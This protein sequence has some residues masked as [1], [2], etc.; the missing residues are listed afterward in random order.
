MAAVSSSTVSV[1]QA[2]ELRAVQALGR[3]DSEVAFKLIDRYCRIGAPRD[4][5]AYVIRSEALIRLGHKGAALSDLMRAL[6]LD[7]EHLIGNRRLLRWG[8]RRQ[9]ERAARTLIKIERDFA[10]LRK[11][12][13][14]LRA[15]GERGAFGAVAALEASIEG[16]AVWRGDAPLEVTVR[17]EES[18]ATV[19]F[20]ADRDHALA[21]LGR[22]VS[23]SVK[24]PESTRSQRIAV[25]ADGQKIC[26][27]V[28]PPRTSPQWAAKEAPDGAETRLASIAVIV[29]IFEDAAA[30][31]ACLD[32]LL[33]ELNENPDCR[34]VLVD[35]ATPNP[36]IKRLIRRA[37]Q[38]PRVAVLTNSYNLGFAG[39][40]NRALCTI[41]TEDVV[42]LNADTMP[43]RRF[44]AR[45]S[46]A[47]RSSPDV[48]VVMPLSNN[49]DL[50]SYPA[51]QQV[52]P[53]GSRQDVERIDRIAATVNAGRIVDIPNGVGFCLYITRACLDK[54]GLLSESFG[55]G[56]FE[57]VE[58]SLRARA[59]GL[60]CV[61]LPSL[62]VGHAGSKSF[63]AEKAPLVARNSGV[64]RVLHPKYAVEFAAFAA[65]DPLRP[66]RQAISLGA[67]FA[68]KDT[69]VVVSGD[70]AVGAVARRRAQ[71]LADAGEAV[72][73][74]EVRRTSAGVQILVSDPAEQPS[75]P[76]LF[77]LRSTSERTALRDLIVAADSSRVEFFDPARTPRELLDILNSSKLEFDIAIAD[78]GLLDRVERA[79]LSA[80]TRE[81]HG[82]SA[83]SGARRR[84]GRLIAEPWRELIGSAKKIVAMDEFGCAF[85]RRIL[86]NREVE[87]IGA[88]LANRKHSE[89]RDAPRRCIGFLPIRIG[90][91]EFR[92]ISAVMRELKAAD[93]QLTF[94]VIGATVNDDALME[95]DG[96]HVTGPFKADELE[97]IA[98]HYAIG[99]LFVST[100]QP[101]FGHPL[102]RAGF[103]CGRPLAY[104]DWSQGA[105]EGAPSDLPLD[106]ELSFN[107]L[108]GALGGWMNVRF[109]RGARS[110]NR[111]Q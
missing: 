41:L 104:F 86:P 75:E 36:K 53:L 71:N 65:T 80:V 88:P 22:A 64:L 78:A 106:P 11:T 76:L 67:G 77:H 105:V 35:D 9:Q 79:S 40:V 13:K 45:L 49:G 68:G 48:G 51:P 6:A 1:S 101:L 83:H 62:Y 52:A 100:V 102:A 15:Q 33:D 94:V 56:Y 82:T 111:F 87:L 7:P 43:P 97:A 91:P 12:L 25:V 73:L 32:C 99:R 26:S 16:W 5:H 42:L 84:R 20:Y 57:D 90:G 103:Q 3:G 46:A 2:L 107:E 81:E 60:R 31:K 109:S 8:D 30:T 70:G 59:H 55:R 61:C 4:A 110:S 14:V 34:V 19:A 108:V 37:S 10:E 63:K 98:E 74:L 47:A 72:R 93:P 96:G 44:I 29:P 69:Q 27:I 39:A 92:L 28:A 85:G 18:A 54:I 17:D 21:D 38:H 89:E 95:I 24:R 66:S 50:A 58:F 23:F